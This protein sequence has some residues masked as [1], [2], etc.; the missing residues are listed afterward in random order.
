MMDKD[1]SGL[2]TFEEWCEFLIFFPHRN[3]EHMVDQWR[4]FAVTTLDP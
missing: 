2:I 4:L 1:R 3:L